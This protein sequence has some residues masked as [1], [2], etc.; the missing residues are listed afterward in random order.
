MDRKNGP[1]IG[2]SWTGE[3]RFSISWNVGFYASRHDRKMTKK[4][5]FHAA[6]LK[7]L[8]RQERGQSGENSSGGMP[9]VAD[10]RID[11]K[12]LQARHGARHWGRTSPTPV[13]SAY[14]ARTAMKKGEPQRARLLSRHCRSNFSVGE[15]N[16]ERLDSNTDEFL[17]KITVSP[18]VTQPAAAGLSRAARACAAWRAWE[19]P[20]ARER[21]PRRLPLD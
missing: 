14:P 21:S 12:M 2:P 16:V 8:A 17:S 11:L 9:G 15:P 20:P 19:P 18:I 6:E 7:S 4:W 1:S 13:N 5:D 3:K 10:S